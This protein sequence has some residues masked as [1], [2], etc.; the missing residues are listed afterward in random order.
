MNKSDAQD[1]SERIA[2]AYAKDVEGFDLSREVEHRVHRAVHDHL[3]EMVP[4][5]AV[6]A[7]LDEAE[8]PKV[9]AL[10]R[11]HL[12]ELTVGEVSEDR[13]PVPTL[14]RMRTVDPAQSSVDCEVKYSGHRQ[15]DLQVVRE[16]LW[17]FRVDDIVLEID[18]YID[19]QRDWVKEDEK[20]ALAL[21]R[22]I[23]RDGLGDQ[24]PLVAV[25]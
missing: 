18:T 12:Y 11:N 8:P 17:R 22:T 19:R 5:D 9:V 6:A 13:V 7:T 1:A 3:R 25:A 21:A 16:S 23:G 24:Q 10:S 2:T 14:L 20:F 15:N 4:D